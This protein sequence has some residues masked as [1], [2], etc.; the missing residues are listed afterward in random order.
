M[1]GLDN[2]LDAQTNDTN[3]LREADHILLF[4]LTLLNEHVDS[5]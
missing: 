3:Y 5:T 2:T 1:Q 4:L